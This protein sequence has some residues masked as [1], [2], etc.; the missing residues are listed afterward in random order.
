M[1]ITIAKASYK[2]N[3]E[4]FKKFFAKNIASDLINERVV[5]VKIQLAKLCRKVPDGYS[6]SLD[7]VRKLFL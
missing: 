2:G 1:Y 5:C 6:K 3:K 4:I 7:K